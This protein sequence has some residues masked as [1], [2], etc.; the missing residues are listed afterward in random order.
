MGTIN[1][2]EILAIGGVAGAPL[3]GGAGRKSVILVIDPGDA[4]AAAAPVG[5]AA[6][7]LQAA[8]TGAG[9]AVVRAARP[10]RGLNIV[11]VGPA[12][13]DRLHDRL[14][15]E[16]F[17]LRRAGDTIT[18][19]GAD[20]RGLSYGLYELM[21]RLRDQPSTALALPEAFGY[22]DQSRAQPHAAI[23]LRGL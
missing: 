6:Q 5:K 22:P 3:L 7:G 23:H 16:S 10:G 19:C 8:L 18:V 11:A 17:T 15:A 1:R 2:R 4:V 21:R 20:A 13:P 9:Y 12:A 14:M